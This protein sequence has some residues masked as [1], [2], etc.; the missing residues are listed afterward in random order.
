MASQSTSPSEYILSLVN[1]TLSNIESAN[2]PLSSIIRKCIRIALLRN[3]YI[4]QWWLEWEMINIADNNLNHKIV[5]QV[6]SH[7][8]K[9]ELG[10]YI[11]EFIKLWNNERRCAAIK[12]NL[13]IEF[14]KNIIP[15]GVGGI[16]IEIRKSKKISSESFPPQGL[17]TLDLYYISKEKDTIRHFMDVVASSYEVVLERIRERAHSFLSETEKQLLFGQINADIFETNRKYVDSKLGKL[18]PAVISQFVAVYK[19]MQDKNP[20]SYAQAA[21]S[22]RRIIKALADTF[23]PP[24]DKPITCADGKKRILSDDKYIN[25]LYQ[26]VYDQNAHSNSSELLL[27]DVEL[28]GN[29]VEKLYNLTCKGTHAEISEFEI[30]QCVIQTYIIAGDILRISDNQSAITIENPQL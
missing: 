9:D 8:T 22:C 28:L 10:I 21:T 23:Y 27:A 13:E 25:R 18:N 24:S 12:D 30:N 11:N 29:K 3:D 17:H 1:D 19:R 4:N 7:F 20:E 5:K 16:E 6:A 14:D 2:I 15:H 26:Y